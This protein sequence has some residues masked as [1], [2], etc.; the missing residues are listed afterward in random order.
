MSWKGLLKVQF[1][2]HLEG[3]TLKTWDRF[4]VQGFI[5]SE[6][7]NVLFPQL[8]G[9]KSGKQQRQEW[10]HLLSLPMSHEKI[11]ISHLCNLGSVLLEVPVPQGGTLFLEDTARVPLN[12]QLW[13][14]QGT[15]DSLCT[16]T[17]RQMEELPLWQ[18]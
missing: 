3:N 5:K 6:T 2:C 10:P 7:S 15:L 11:C 4:G 17:S 8:E 18:G 13:L 16:E 12:Y 1:N 14:P 9:Y